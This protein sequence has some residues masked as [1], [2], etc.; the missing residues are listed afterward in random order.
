[1]IQTQL[2]KLTRAA[3]EHPSSPVLAMRQRRM[4]EFLRRLQPKRGARILDLGGSPEIWTLTPERFEITLV[5]LPG[6][7]DRLAGA[8]PEARGDHRIV[9][10]D[11]C[12][13]RGIFED[14]SFDIV[15]SNSVIEH[16][17]GAERRRDFAREVRR[18]APAY[19]V[20]TPSPRFPIEPHTGVPFYFQLPS[21]LRE[22]L[23]KRWREAL[24]AWAEMIEETTVL[25][26]TEMRAL[27]PDGEIFLE[28]ALGLE[29]S[30]CSYRRARPH[31]SA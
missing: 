24:P 7:M 31:A 11:A 28:R 2:R 4:Q 16:V 22:R 14:N 27:F 12:D 23:M 17:G 21:H 15:F 13:L 25:S 6:G 5:N 10:A 26:E 19:W 30:I 9:W 3:Y 18:L 8:Q 29:K 20:Q 1:M